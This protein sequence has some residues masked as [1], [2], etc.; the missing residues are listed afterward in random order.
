VGLN[1]I[2]E[3]VGAEVVLVRTMGLRPGGQSLPVLRF[4]ADESDEGADSA[5]VLVGECHGV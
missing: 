1:V 2:V 3:H 5:G 4:P